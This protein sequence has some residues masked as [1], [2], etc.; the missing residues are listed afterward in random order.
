MHLKSDTIALIPHITHEIYRKRKPIA[1]VYSKANAQHP[2]EIAM[3][4]LT[5]IRLMEKAGK[6][7]MFPF[8]SSAR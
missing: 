1:M 3:I 5:K 6:H 7:A 4:T 8:K 2:G